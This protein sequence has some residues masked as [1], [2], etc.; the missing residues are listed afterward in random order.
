MRGREPETSGGWGGLPP[1]H[2]LGT[3]LHAG[4]LRGWGTPQLMPPATHSH[5]LTHRHNHV[6]THSHAHTH[7]HTQ[8]RNP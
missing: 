3:V 5:S 6:Y 1:L 2:R 4:F 7:A 8:A